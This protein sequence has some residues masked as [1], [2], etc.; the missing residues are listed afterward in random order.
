MRIF[1]TGGAG[2]I[3]SALCDRLIKRG[4]YVASY[5]A[6]LNFSNNDLYY[7]KCL[8]LR[9]KLYEQ[10]KHYKGDIRNFSLLTRAVRSFKPDIIVHLAGL[11]MARVPKNH[12]DQMIPINM[13]GTL[14]VLKAFESSTAKKIIYASSSM[15]YGHFTQT[16][17]S[18]EYIL[19]PTN[20]YGV[21]KASGEY[22]VSLSKKKWV[23]VR[24][25]AV[26]GYADCANRIT[27]VLTDAAIQNTPAWIVKGET[28]DFTYIDDVIDGYMKC[29]F[30][31]KA[32]G[33]A[34][35]ISRGEVRSTAEFAEVVN[36]YYPKFVY[37]IK[38]PP[39]DQVWRGALDISKARTILGYNPKFT[40]EKG[41]K[42]MLSYV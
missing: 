35:N 26:Y 33:E 30:N 9:K 3:G 8:R 36:S 11:T 10:P 14:N 42:K 22:F 23:I 27:Q 29:I 16:P 21:C 7:R 34:F 4:H 2:F 37:E 6:Y 31:S 41:I 38:D 40:I 15:A 39:K 20:A 1:V 12:E 19:K 17:Q 28:L 13:I 25:T 5:D 18:E 24:A 32:V